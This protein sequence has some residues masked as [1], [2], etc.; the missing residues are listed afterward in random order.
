M[1]DSQASPAH[2]LAPTNRVLIALRLL[3]AGQEGEQQSFSYILAPQGLSP[4]DA[5]LSGPQASIR[6]GNTLPLRVSRE[7]DAG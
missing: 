2:C 5:V 6:P 1:G 3:P 4:G 7:A